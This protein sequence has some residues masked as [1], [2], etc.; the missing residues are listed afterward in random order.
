MKYILSVFLMCIF[1]ATTLLGCDRVKQATDVIDN[2]KTFSDD[3]Q[4]KVK[5]I[6]PGSNQK[7]S[8]SKKGESGNKDKGEEKGQDDD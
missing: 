6:I 5:E 4:K 3:L 7:E 1:L 2:A 8:D